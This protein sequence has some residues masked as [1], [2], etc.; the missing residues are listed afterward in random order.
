M[1]EEEEEEEDKEGHPTRTMVVARGSRASTKCL[2]TRPGLVATTHMR[3]HPGAIAHPSDLGR[4]DALACRAG[5]ACARL[6]F[7][8]YGMGLIAGVT[9]GQCWRW[10]NDGWGFMGHGVTR[11]WWH[12]MLA[13]GRCNQQTRNKQNNKCMKDA[14]VLVMRIAV[15]S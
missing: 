3:L 9:W 2:P 10:A 15:C 6:R 13:L 11:A 5:H 7:V 4:V 8:Y 1:E 14:S 12:P